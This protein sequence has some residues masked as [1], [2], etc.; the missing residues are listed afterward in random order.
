MYYDCKKDCS[1]Q[2]QERSDKS[3]LIPK[4]RVDS[5][6]GKAIII[7]MFDNY[8]AANETGLIIMRYILQKYSI[9]DIIQTIRVI[10]PDAYEKALQ[11]DINIFINKL[12]KR[13]MIELE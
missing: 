5:I 10:H 3:K 4:Y 7:D 13:K 8:Y 9:N 1:L 2:V 11:S 6:N 12:I